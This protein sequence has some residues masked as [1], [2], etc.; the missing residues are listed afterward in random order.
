MNKAGQRKRWLAIQMLLF[1]IDIA[2]ALASK[3]LGYPL[4]TMPLPLFF[5]S[6]PHDVDLFPLAEYPSP[7]V[8]K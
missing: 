1:V 6:H 8:V 5:L 3:A 2:G 7:L 4:Q